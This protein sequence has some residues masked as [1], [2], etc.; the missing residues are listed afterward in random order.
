ML[1]GSTVMIMKLQTLVAFLPFLAFEVGDVFAALEALVTGP[2]SSSAVLFV[3]DR[4]QVELVTL[5][6]T[7]LPYG[8]RRG[9]FQGFG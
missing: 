7:C 5:R 3:P 1:D 2:E 8:R 9:M 6:E 4:S